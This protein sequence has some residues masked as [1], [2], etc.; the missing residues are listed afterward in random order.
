MTATD[1]TAAAVARGEPPD[2]P[3][4]D[5]TRTLLASDVGIDGAVAARLRE[6]SRR[7][8]ARIEHR[9]VTAGHLLE[10]G[11]VVPTG[12]PPD[13]SE[14]VDAWRDLTD[15]LDH[16]V[17]LL[18]HID[19][20]HERRLR[21]ASPRERRAATRVL[22][23]ALHRIVDGYDV[24][25]EPPHRP[26][27]AARSADEWLGRMLGRAA[28]G[29]RRPQGSVN[30]W[31]RNGRWTR[32]GLALTAALLL[33][34]GAAVAAA[35]VVAVRSALSV[36][37]FA[38]E[39]PDGRPVRVLGYDPAWAAFVCTH[40]GDAA[41][42]AGLGLGLYLAGHPAWGA[43]T[44]FAALFSLVA[45]MLRIASGHHGFRL[46]RLWLDRAITTAALTAATAGAALA[47]PGGP[48]VVRGI[49]A[50]VV[51]VAAVVLVGVVE[52]GR[53]VYYAFRRR[54]LFRQVAAAET[55]TVPDVLVARTG[56][57]LVMNISRLDAHR[58]IV[59]H[60]SARSAPSAP[61]LRVVGEWPDVADSSGAGAVR[62]ARRGRAGPRTS[63]RG[64]RRA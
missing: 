15:M 6:E 43:V 34:V 47:D 2:D 35:L 45:S 22:A 57:G 37:L 40:L 62:P 3:D 12:A 11:T 9:L 48:G 8:R 5:A 1:H 52:I 64:H 23:E 14:T 17:D 49:P 53:T 16:D 25:I 50:A 26:V 31:A 30:W 55:G 44:A 56:D 36:T 58:R 24:E 20:L 54:R 27:M 21:S 33:A 28:V 46:P 59:D 42:V 63:G 7:T 29:G 51:A 13:G 18:E 4:P 61:R 19:A 60:P 39:A 38:P 10:D 32:L 41:I